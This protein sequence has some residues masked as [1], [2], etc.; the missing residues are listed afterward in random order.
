M[1]MYQTGSPTRRTPERYNERSPDRREAGE[2]RVTSRTALAGASHGPDST[3]ECKLKMKFIR[4]FVRFLYVI[5]GDTRTE[6]IK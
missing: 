1:K 4:S 6:C 5:G 2:L 3:G